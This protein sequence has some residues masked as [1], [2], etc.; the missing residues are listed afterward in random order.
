MCVF[1]SPH[2]S[3]RLNAVIHTIPYFD[4]QEISVFQGSDK[5]S[6]QSISSGGGVPLA[7][8]GVKVC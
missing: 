2:S 8:L 3:S 5:G 4:L 7:P 1:P 6:D